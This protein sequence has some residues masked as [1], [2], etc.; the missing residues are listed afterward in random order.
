MD[1]IYMQMK[2]IKRGEY[3]LEIWAVQKKKKKKRE[4][5]TQSRYER[6]IINLLLRSTMLYNIHKVHSGGFLQELDTN[7]TQTYF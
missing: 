1:L 7:V 2:A 3:T 6:S 5:W 4:C